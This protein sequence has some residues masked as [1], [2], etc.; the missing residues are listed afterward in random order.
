MPQPSSSRAAFTLI[1]LL[2]VIA[3]IA[4]LAAI[5]FPVFAQARENARK[6]VC[7]SNEKQI[8]TATALYYHDYDERFCAQPVEASAI[9][10]AGG[11]SWN[12]YNA[13]FP[14]LKNKQVWLC[15]DDVANTNPVLKVEPPNMGYH[16]N[17]NIIMGSVSMP[18]AAMLAEI[19]APS[20]LVLMR[21][22]GVGTVYNRAYLRP[23][24]G[25]CDDTIGWTPPPGSQ[26]RFP[27]RNGI[28]L[29]ITDTHVK[30][31][32]PS[33]SL[34]LSQFPNDTG[35][36]TLTLHPGAAYCQ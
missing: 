18:K 26:N 31:Y 3:I 9:Q 6:T 33:S 21:E 27:H 13:L 12:Y 15:P 25:Q 22:S 11:D 14:Y 34:F 19:Q 35:A 4:I 28:N 7:V 17:G 8:G 24:P 36:S 2:V 32:L 20:N 5:L 30:W 23:Y 1:E 10:E 29:L 16:F